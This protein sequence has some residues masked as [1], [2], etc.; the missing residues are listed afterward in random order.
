MFLQL[1]NVYTTRKLR[2]NNTQH[3]YYSYD[4]SGFS[5]RVDCLFVVGALGYVF[6]GVVACLFNGVLVC[7][8]LFACL[9][10][11]KLVVCLDDIPYREPKIPQML[12]V[13]LDENTYLSSHCEIGV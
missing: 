6:L 12:T 13:S 5:N 11:F 2:Y 8:C 9:L 7:F 4:Y 1:N 10:F 3:N